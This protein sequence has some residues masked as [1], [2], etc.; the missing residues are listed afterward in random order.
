LNKG[1]ENLMTDNVTREQAGKQKERQAGLF[2]RW[3]ILSF[4][5]LLIGAGWIWVS[6]VTGTTSDAQIQAAHEGFLAPDFSLQTLSGETVTLSNLRGKPVLIN[7]WASWCIPCRLEMPA[8]QRVYQNYQAQGFQVLAVNATNQD[9]PGKVAEFAQQYGLKFPILL[10]KL[11][12][13]G[14]QYQLESLP[15]SFFVDTQGVIREVIVGGP[16]SEAL[17]QVR[18]EN[19]L[20][21][22]R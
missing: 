17:L 10:D 22:S 15:T 16:M 1:S 7:L 19:L 6:R 21:E 5:I 8:L 4:I 9:D 2:S 12:S 3:T 20:K 11:G 14:Q 18:V 13:V